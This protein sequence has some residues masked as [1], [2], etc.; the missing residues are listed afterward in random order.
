MSELELESK[1]LWF[2]SLGFF[3]FFHWNTLRIHWNTLRI[4][5]IDLKEKSKPK[6]KRKQNPANFN[7]RDYPILLSILKIIFHK[8]IVRKFESLDIKCAGHKKKL[9]LNSLFFQVCNLY[10]Y[11]Q[12]VVVL[13]LQKR[14]CFQSLFSFLTE[15]YFW[16]L[17]KYF[18]SIFYNHCSYPPSDFSRILF[19]FQIIRKISC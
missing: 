11:Q 5:C 14:L 10:F 17:G 7:C 3:F 15:E 18:I 8:V 12:V 9:N 19:S 1:Y 4:S 6:N 13:L 16:L 2:Q